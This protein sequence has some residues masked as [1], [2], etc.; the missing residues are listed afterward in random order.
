M[1]RTRPADC[2][3]AEVETRLAQGCRPRDLV[4]P[5]EERRTDRHGS[6]R[7]MR[8]SARRLMEKLGKTDLEMSCVPSIRSDSLDGRH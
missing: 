8:C 4:E 3:V 5:K 7:A 2:D 1:R 6:D